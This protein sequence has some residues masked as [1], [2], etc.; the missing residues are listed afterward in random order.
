MEQEL[1]QLSMEETRLMEELEQLKLEN[2]N[3][4]Q[5]LDSQHKARKHNL[6]I[7]LVVFTCDIRNVE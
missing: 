4:D 3:I 5:E 1:E 6:K 7:I 2:K